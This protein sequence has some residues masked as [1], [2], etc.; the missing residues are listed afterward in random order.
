M[1]SRLISTR[2]QRRARGRSPRD[3]QPGED[4]TPQRQAEDSPRPRQRARGGPEQASVPRKKGAQGLSQRLEA[5]LAGSVADETEILCLEIR[6]GEASTGKGEATPPLRVHSVVA[7]RVL[8]RGRPGFYLTDRAEPHELADAVRMALAHSRSTPRLD[9]APGFAPSEDGGEGRLPE[10]VLFDPEIAS[11]D[12][13]AGRA[14]LSRWTERGERARLRWSAARVSLVNSRGLDRDIRVTGVELEV[15]AGRGFAAATAR[16][17][18]R[19]LAGLRPE[20]I[21]ERARLRLSPTGEIG[22]VP[23]RAAPLVLSPEVCAGLVD[24]LNRAALTAEAFRQGPPLSPGALGEP[25]FAPGV[26]L[27]DDGSDPVG[28]ALPFDF[29]GWPRKRVEMVVGGILRTPAVDA[30]LAT[31]HGLSPTPHFLAPDE[32]RASHLFLLPGSASTDELL[33]RAAGGL[34]IGRLSGLVLDHPGRLTFRAEAREARQITAAG[35]IGAPVP[36]FLWEDDL[37]RVLRE[38]ETAGTEPITLATDH[39]L[40]ESVSAPA[41]AVRAGG[42]FRPLRENPTPTDS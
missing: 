15:H 33:A 25:L 38:I 19:T 35:Q 20:V 16:G 30:P 11:L 14:L 5:T 13:R 27:W 32:H 4:E 26:S 29:A 2:P 17:A 1:R 21:V 28:L 9:P 42:C 6:C 37:L 31:A 39:H 3:R 40:L 24:R 41:V 34:W 7:V 22:E 18:A 8:D 36:D 23:A 12:P 10:A